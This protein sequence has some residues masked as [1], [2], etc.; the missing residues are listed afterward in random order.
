[1]FEI[2]VRSSFAAA[3]RLNNHR[4]KCCRLHGHTWEV[5]AVVA[6][7]E[8]NDT[9]MLIDFSVLKHELREVVGVF[10]HS[11]LNELAPFSGGHPGNNPTAENL[12]RHIFSEL[13]ARL[14][15]YRPPATLVSVTVWESPGAAVTY[16][17]E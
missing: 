3:H 17:E 2:R 5:E 7:R 15:E 13:K 6:G 1:M 10:D 14:S 8:L 9:G 11:F 16:R 12:A 4:D